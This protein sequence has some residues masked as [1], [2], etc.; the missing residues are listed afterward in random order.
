MSMLDKY[1]SWVDN[2]GIE[3]FNVEDYEEIDV[4]VDYIFLSYCVFILCI[5]FV[6]LDK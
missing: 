3:E 4:P 2:K 5:P 1:V 6:A